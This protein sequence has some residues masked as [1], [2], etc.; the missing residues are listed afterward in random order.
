MRSSCT[1]ATHHGV[2]LRIDDLLWTKRA[3]SGWSAYAESKFCDV[4]LAFAT[5]R[6]WKAVR[7]N[8]LEPGWVPTKMGGPSAP[9]D[10]RLGSVTQAWLATSEDTL[11]RSRGGY[12]YHQRLRAPNAIANDVETQEALLAE[13]GRISGVPLTD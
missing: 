4:L 8:A 2:R 1:G 13:C 9:D 5:A 7:S 12:F 10:L 6:R 11:A 3:W